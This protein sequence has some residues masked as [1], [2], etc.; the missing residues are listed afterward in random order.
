M[1]L[2]KAE[3][4]EIHGAGNKRFAIAASRFNCDFVDAMVKDA[5]STL[6]ENG[7][8]PENIK[9]V[10]EYLDD[11]VDDR[12]WSDAKYEAMMDELIYKL[13]TKQEEWS[14]EK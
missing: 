3:M 6:I 7:V 12:D 14:K 11:V 4:R 1:S 9:I 8:E 2:L 10:R 13:Y 5:R